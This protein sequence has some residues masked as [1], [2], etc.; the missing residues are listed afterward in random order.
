[1]FN[2]CNKFPTIDLCSSFCMY[3]DEF[4]GNIIPFCILDS[5]DFFTHLFKLE[6]TTKLLALILNLGHLLH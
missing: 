5:P 3:K 2:T 4:A 6:V 1:M